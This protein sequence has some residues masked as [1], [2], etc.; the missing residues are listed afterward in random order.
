MAEVNGLNFIKIDPPERERTYVFP[1]AQ[2]ISFKNVEAIC[3]RESGNHRLNLQS[4]KKAIVKNEW[5]AIILDT[6]EWTF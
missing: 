6:D 4:G 3:I 2:E 1:D 5:R